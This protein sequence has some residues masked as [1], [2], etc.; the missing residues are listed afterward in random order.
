MAALSVFRGGF[1]RATAQKVTGAALGDLMR[2]ID[3]SL[4]HR[5]SANRYEV[6]EL[7]R[8][9][10]AEKLGENPAVEAAIRDHHSE[11]YCQ[12]LKN[13]EIDLEGPEQGAAM[14]EIAVD[15]DNIHGAWEW[16]VDTDNIKALLGAINGLCHFYERRNQHLEGEKVCR[17]LAK[18]LGALQDSDQPQMGSSEDERG[19]Q[20]DILKLQVRALSWSGYFNLFLLNTDL[21][22]E[23]INQG[24]IL[25]EETKIP[26][27]ETRFEKA[28]VMLMLSSTLGAKSRIDAKKL[29]EKSLKSFSSQDKS[30]WMG[31]TLDNL[32]HLEVSM[33]QRKKYFKES[34][35]VRKKHGDLRGTAD[36]LTQLSREAANQGQFE[37]ADRFIREALLICEELDD[38]PLILAKYWLLGSLLV[39][40]GK[41]SEAR[42]MEQEKLAIYNDLGS[43]HQ[44]VW[45]NAIAG[46]PDLYMGAYGDAYNQAEIGLTLSQKANHR[47]SL[48]GTILSTTI[49]AR[50]NLVK[51]SYDKAKRLFQ[52]NILI[53]H[54]VGWRDML[55]QDL[56]CQ[57]YAARGLGQ[58]SLAQG[59]FYKA[60]KIAVETKR[61][62]SLSHTLPGIALLFADRGDVER[63]VELYALVSTLGMVA[64]SK[65][66]DDIAGDE[67]AAVAE[68]LPVDVA[69]AAKA[70]GRLLDLWETADGHVGGVGCVGV[71]QCRPIKG[72]LLMGVIFML[73][74]RGAVEYSR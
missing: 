16:A 31:M 20:I 41:F 50:V 12:A 22:H 65:W 9:Y 49:L 67:I 43:P 46:F 21:A 17:F 51:G 69:E 61:F 71:G 7:L 10:S 52:E 55:G 45:I 24:I 35:A 36:S 74:Y 58:I 3:K 29:A 63:A 28:M 73:F 38:Q 56:G 1:T 2:L 32:G 72:K 48:N 11:T 59:H 66:F 39:W 70:R 5:T 40:Q 25:L 33:V 14:K 57:G 27:E 37:Q 60:L 18:K 19:S 4:L 64:N 26:S 6:H 42:L 68:E 54:S 23:L 47:D 53:S 34:L 62:L 13:W 15:I 8:Q 30:W 44:L